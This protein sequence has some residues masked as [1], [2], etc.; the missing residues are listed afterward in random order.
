MTSFLVTVIVGQDRPAGEIQARHSIR[1]LDALP[2][3][4]LLCDRYAIRPCYLLTYP[5]MRSDRHDWFMRQAKH[6]KADL[7]ICFQSWTTPPF[8]ASENRLTRTPITAL[9]VNR[10]FGKWTSLKTL[11]EERFRIEPRLSCVDGGAVS[12]ASLQALE[13]LGIHVDTSALPRLDFSS[14][15]GSDWTKTTRA[16]YHPSRQCPERTG[17]S[18]VLEI[19][20]TTGAT[21]PESL[22]SLSRLRRIAQGGLT[23]RLLDSTLFSLGPVH[24]LSPAHLTLSAMTSIADSIH[25]QALPQ[26]HMRILSETLSAGDS[27]LSAT[28]KQTASTFSRID[29]FYRYVIDTLQLTPESVSDFA[30]HR[31]RPG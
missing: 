25:R 15:G 16:P 7:G 30:E 14:A 28:A 31:L 26:L 13:A 29:G 21:W 20:V 8:E 22:G 3:F 23:L 19:P 18:P 27:A 11:F 17:Y 9:A 24:A 12:G 1:N 6:G 10:V 4:Q 5:V 2:K